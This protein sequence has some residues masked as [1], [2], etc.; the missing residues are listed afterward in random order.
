MSGASPA[1]FWDWQEQSKAFEQIAA[2]RGGG[3]TLTLGEH[4]EVFPGAGVSINFFDTMG[5]KPL[6]GRTFLPEEGKSS[7]PGAVILS[8]KL[9]QSRFGGDPTVIGRSVKTSDGATTIVGVM[10]PDFKYPMFADLWTPLARD[11]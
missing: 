7:G 8:Y 1:D 10:P 3:E 11:A 5:V 2:M 6:I 4:P 9:W